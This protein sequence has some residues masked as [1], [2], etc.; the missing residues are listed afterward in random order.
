MD[1]EVGNVVS[2]GVPVVDELLEPHAQ[3]LGPLMP[4]LGLAVY[5]AARLEFTLR[6]VHSVAL[7]APMKLGLPQGQVASQ[8]TDA[9]SRGEDDIEVGIVTAWLS[10]ASDALTER[11]G[12]AHAL[13]SV[14]SD[15]LPE[16]MERSGV[17]EEEIAA[18]VPGVVHRSELKSERTLR[19][20]TDDLDELC[21]NMSRL[22][23]N[24]GRVVKMTRSAT[25]AT[26]A[27]EDVR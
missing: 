13:W 21:R 22:L 12:L 27:N 15:V 25:G 20:T 8:A 10:E 16:D 7:N 11:G 14:T 24:A 1:R 6:F 2:A 3:Q 26:R 5:L 9:V 18:H 17:T 19:T 4:R 23:E